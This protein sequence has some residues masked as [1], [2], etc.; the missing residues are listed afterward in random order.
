MNK[1]QYIFWDEQWSGEVDV[2][3]TGSND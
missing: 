3:T 2:S 1:T